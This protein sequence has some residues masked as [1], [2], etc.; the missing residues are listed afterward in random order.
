[1]SAAPLPAGFAPVFAGWNVWDIYQANTPDEGVLGTLWHAGIS[2]DELLQ[3]WVVDQI[4]DNAPGANLSDPLNPDP[5]KFRG[6]VVQI[7]P[8]AGTLARA[9]VRDAIPTLAGAQQLGTANS[10]ARLV[11]VRFYNRGA[12]STMPWPHDQNFLVDSVFAPDA[13][14]MIT[15]SP[16]PSTAA[17]TL[18]DIG[19]G[20]GHGLETL[21]WVVGGAAAIF[22]I[23]KFVGSRQS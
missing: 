2:Q 13:G 21:A 3:T 5:R 19:S 8:N 18:S 16:A 7:I 10:T 9:A 11:T 15:N 6:D 12:A 4:E 20:I 1:M 14:N 22:L 17:G 23:S